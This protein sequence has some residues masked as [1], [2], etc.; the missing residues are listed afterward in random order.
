MFGKG[1]LAV[2]EEEA[3]DEAEGGESAD[4]EESTEE[5]DFG[6][7]RQELLAEKAGIKDLAAF[8]KLLAACNEG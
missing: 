5:V 8:K 6:A 1:K 3:A 4:A 2:Y 7:K